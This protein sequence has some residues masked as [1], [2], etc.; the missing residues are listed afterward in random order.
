VNRE[1]GSRRAPRR[2]LACAALAAV[3]AVAVSVP[4][5]SGFGAPAKRP[6]SVAVLDDYYSP[7]SLD[8]KPGTKVVWKWSDANV[9]S[10]NVKLIRAPKGVK[11]ARFK[12]PTAATGIVFAR[13]LRVTGRYHFECTLHPTVMELHVRVKERANVPDGPG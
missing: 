9:D 2:R 12:S 3:G 4:A 1:Q 13:R 5:T 11:K 8:L 10:H 7:S 6:V